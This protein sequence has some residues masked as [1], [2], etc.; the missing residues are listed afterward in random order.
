VCGVGV[1]V[2]APTLA[3]DEARAADA[4]SR[5]AHA[6]VI[7]LAL[8]VAT[9]ARIVVQIHAVAVARGQASATHALAGRAISERRVA[10]ARLALRVRATQRLACGAIRVAQALAAVKAQ[11][12]GLVAATVASSQAL[13]ASALR[14]HADAVLASARAVVG[15]LDADPERVAHGLLAIAAVRVELTGEAAS[16]LDVAARQILVAAVCVAPAAGLAALLQ[17]VA[18]G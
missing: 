10:V 16:G 2:D 13:L 15:A 7:A 18:D 12:V 17:G 11:A 14:W 9:V 6:V 5:R 1:G 4:P 8:A 3:L